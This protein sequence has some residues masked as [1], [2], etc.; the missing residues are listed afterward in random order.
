MCSETRFSQLKMV[1]CPW[2]PR[3]PQ[4]YVWNWILL[5]GKWNAKTAPAMGTRCLE[6]VHRSEAHSGVGQEGRWAH[7]EEAVPWEKQG[8]PQDSAS[9][10]AAM[11][12]RD[13]QWR[14]GLLSLMD[15][16]VWLLLCVSIGITEVMSPVGVFQHFERAKISLSQLM[17]VPLCAECQSEPSNIQLHDC[18]VLQCPCSHVLSPRLLNQVAPG[19]Y[20]LDVYRWAAFRADEPGWAGEPGCWWAEAA[21][22]K[23]SFYYQCRQGFHGRPESCQMQNLKV[24]TVLMLSDPHS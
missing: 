20:H 5:H 3:V 23:T 6:G 16:G 7:T 12:S 2:Q 18:K 13:K 22:N 17:C 8:A 10:R 19:P 15:Q 11:P 21:S 1:F 24:F 14:A 9:P 4:Q